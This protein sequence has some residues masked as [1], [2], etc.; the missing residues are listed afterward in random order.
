MR[1]ILVVVGVLVLLMGVVWSLQGLG[2]ILG[3]FMSNNPTWIGI[4]AAT[5]VVG[6]VLAIAGVRSGPPTKNP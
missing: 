2:M 5:A 6:V 3:S 4:G 1:M